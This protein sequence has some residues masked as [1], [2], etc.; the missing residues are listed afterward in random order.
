MT[1]LHGGEITELPQ[2]YGFKP[3][4]TAAMNRIFSLARFALFFVASSLL[5]AAP[6]IDPS[7]WLECQCFVKDS[8]MIVKNPG[9]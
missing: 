4:R 7:V 5:Q 1:P 9:K 8:P 6:D 3:I 2:A